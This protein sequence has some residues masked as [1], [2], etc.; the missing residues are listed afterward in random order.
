VAVDGED[1]S[2]VGLWDGG[3]KILGYV[4]FVLEGLCEGSDA[5]AGLNRVMR[6]ED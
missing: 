4:A 5:E 2:E 1:G 6:T 3:G